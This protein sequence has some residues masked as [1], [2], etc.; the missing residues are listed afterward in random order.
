MWLAN[1]A[2]YKPFLNAY[3]VI[4]TFSPT[5]RFDVL[6]YVICYLLFVLL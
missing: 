1:G 5:V 4:F 3:Y 6:T 2:A